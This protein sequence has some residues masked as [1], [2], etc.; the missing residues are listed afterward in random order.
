MN[1]ATP[2]NNDLAQTSPKFILAAVPE[3]LGAVLSSNAKATKIFANNPRLAVCNIVQ[4]PLPKSLK[5]ETADNTPKVIHLILP[6][7]SVIASI[8]AAE[9]EMRASGKKHPVTVGKP[10]EHGDTLQIHTFG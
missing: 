7:Y 8:K 10:Q 1:P 2:S 5:I 3:I 4:R 6:Y 9:A